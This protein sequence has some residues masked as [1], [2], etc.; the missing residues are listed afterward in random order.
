MFIPSQGF[1]RSALGVLKAICGS[2]PVKVE[3]I[4]CG[5]AEIV[6]D[7]IN[8]HAR[9]AGVS[10]IGCATIAALVLRHPANC[11]EVMK[12]NAAECIVRC[13][14]LHKGSVNVQVLLR[15]VGE[16]GG[17]DVYCEGGCGGSF[18]SGLQRSGCIQFETRVEVND[19]L[20]FL[21]IPT[22]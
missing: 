2:D 20:I 18:R 7:S 19:C 16:G 5:G 10:E 12:C 22:I 11:A 9:S 3:V 6:L 8:T 13:L 4:R 14:Q 1:V 21:L 17:L 15:G